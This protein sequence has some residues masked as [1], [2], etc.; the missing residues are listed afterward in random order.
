M[1]ERASVVTIN[2]DFDIEG[3]LQADPF[4]DRYE[5]SMLFEQTRRSMAAALQRQLNGMTCETHNKEPVITITGRYDTD[6]EELDIQYHLDT[7]CKLFMLR[8]IQR[9]NN[10]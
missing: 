7:C 6:R 9:M 8:V 4:L 1:L 3:A 5:L 10:R 2:D